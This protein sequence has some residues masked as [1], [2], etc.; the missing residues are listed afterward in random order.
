[1]KD[2][3]AH[4]LR[5]DQIRDGE[6]IDLPPTRPS[7][8]PIADRFGLQSIERL[9]AHATFSRKADLVRAEGR[10][11]ASLDQSCVITGEPVPAHSTSRLRLR[12]C[13]SLK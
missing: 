4:R 6:R 10:V 3:F 9:E 2:G 12:S 1:M 5:L 11:T 7:G 13:P 8:G